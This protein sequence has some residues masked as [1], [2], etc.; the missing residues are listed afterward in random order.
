MIDFK[1]SDAEKKIARRA[2]D[3]ALKNECAAIM[4]KLKGLAAKAENPEDICAI[5]DYLTEQRRAIDGKYDYR[6]SQL[7]VVFGRLLREN[8]IEAKYLKG[9]SEEKLAAILRLI[10][11]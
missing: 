5:H 8:W 1:W 2:F 11:L 9:P 3:A 6:Y 10:S 4:Q 7:S